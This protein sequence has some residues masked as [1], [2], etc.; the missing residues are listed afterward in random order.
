MA[1]DLF[2]RRQVSGSFSRDK[3]ATAAVAVT[4]VGVLA[5]LGSLF[6]LHKARRAAENQRY[7]REYG[8]GLKTTM[9]VPAISDRDLVMFPHDAWR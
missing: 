3:S 1:Y 9:E 2:Y 4:G 5:L 6:M 7:R 8:R